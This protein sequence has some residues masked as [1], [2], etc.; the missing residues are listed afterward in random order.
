MNRRP[1]AWLLTCLMIVLLAAAL[2]MAQDTA[3]TRSAATLQIETD[4]RLERKLLALDLAAFR[5]ARTVE[6]RTRDQVTAV[7]GRLDQALAGNTIGLGNLEALHLERSRLI[8]TSTSNAP[9]RRSRPTAWSGRS[10]AWRTGCGGSG[11]WKGR[12]AG[13][14]RP[15]TRSPAPGA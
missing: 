2:A 4:L 9:R 6:V 10:S 8:P 14:A 7:T 15:R 13:P 11:S 5:E 1:A 3:A 12:P